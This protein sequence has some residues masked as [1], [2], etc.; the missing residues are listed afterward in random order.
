MSR[1]VLV[2]DEEALLISQLTEV[3]RVHGVSVIPVRR[4]RLVQQA[5]KDVPAMVVLDVSHAD[6]LEELSLLKSIRATADVPVVVIAAHDDP[7]LRDLAL[8]LGADGFIPR[9]LPVDLGAKL[10]ALLQG[11]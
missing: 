7:E 1:T 10:F 11:R 4:K 5:K 2:T 3:A 9:P 6:G 8:E